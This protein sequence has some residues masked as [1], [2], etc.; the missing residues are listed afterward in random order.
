METLQT[1]TIKS[2]VTSDYR[3]AAIFEKY[4]LDFCCKGGVTIEQACSEKKIDAASIYAEL[5]Q[6]ATVAQ[7]DAP[8]FS[9]WPLDELIDYII[10][11]HHKYVRESTPV[12]SAHTQKVGTVHGS[13]HPEVVK[14]ARHFE[15]VAEE[16][17]RHMM[18]EE[19]ML[20][21]YI[22]S[23]VK[24]KRNGKAAIPAPFGTVQNPIRMMEAEHRAAGDEL[25]EVRSLSNNY[26]PPEDACTTYRVSFQELQQFEQDLHQHVH[27]ENNILF[28]KAIALEQELRNS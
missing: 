16:L 20:F 25:Y 9:N 10:N 28:P 15:A 24:A 5:G 1:K 18:K 19:L 6:L 22:K 7:P 17:Q 27:L 21:P 26:N 14:I 12:I 13:N 3:A 2:I 23:L 4:S 11:V 8:R